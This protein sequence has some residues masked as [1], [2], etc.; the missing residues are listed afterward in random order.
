MLSKV[1][2]SSEYT[3]YM[4]KRGTVL[5]LFSFL[6]NLDIIS[7]I[8][9]SHELSLVLHSVHSGCNHRPRGKLSMKDIKRR[10]FHA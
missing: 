2:E 1:F 10:D 9:S 4:E 7:V 3:Y 8:M 6:V 5:L